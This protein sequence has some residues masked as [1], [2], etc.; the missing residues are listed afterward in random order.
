[1][2]P[3][4]TN[5][6]RHE[7][8]DLIGQGD[9]PSDGELTSA[10]DPLLSPQPGLRCFVWKPGLTC[11]AG[12]RQADKSWVTGAGTNPTMRVRC[13]ASMRAVLGCGNA[14]L[15]IQLVSVG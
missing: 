14:R 6:S 13:L 1:M 12:Q 3:A 10:S 9:G 5:I 4:P 15:V 11:T 8:P 7:L 2:R